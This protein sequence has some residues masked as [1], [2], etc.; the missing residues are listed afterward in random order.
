MPERT[1]LERLAE[2][3]ARRAQPSQAGPNAATPTVAVRHGAPSRAFGPA[4]V[5][6]MQRHA[7]N[8]AVVARLRRSGEDAESTVAGS[9]AQGG[10]MGEMAGDAMAG[11]KMAGTGAAAMVEA[12][13]GGEDGGGAGSAVGDEVA[14]GR[15][16]LSGSGAR[17]E[18]AS[19]AAAAAMAGSS[20][21]ASA[22]AGEQAFSTSGASAGGAAQAASMAEASA[23]SAV[24]GAAS[25][26]MTE[27]GGAAQDGSLAGGAAMGGETAAGSAVSGAASGAMTEHVGAQGAASVAQGAGTEHGGAAQGGETIAGSA[28]S[29]AAQ[30]GEKAVGS[31][32]SGGGAGA[33]TD[34]VGAQGAES[35]AAAAVGGEAPSATGAETA[36]HP[37]AGSRSGGAGAHAEGRT[38]GGAG[39]GGAGAA[40]AGP[41]EDAA[42]GG[43]MG[44]GG[45]PAS[46]EEVDELPEPGPISMA[47]VA[48]LGQP[49]EL[50]TEAPIEEPGEITA[51]EAPALEGQVSGIEGAVGSGGG[52]VLD[53]IVDR[54][55]GFFRPVT[56][57][58]STGLRN[59]ASGVVTRIGNIATSAWTAARGL[60]TSV[61]NGFRSLAG[62]ILGEIRSHLGDLQAG[63]R[64]IVGQVFGAVRG[65]MGRIGGAIRSAVSGILSGRPVMATL[66]A[67][68]KAVF[69]GMFGAIT[70]RIRAI[71][72]R[73]RGVVNG[74]L[75]R[76]VSGAA[77]L[78]Q[79]AQAG[80][81]A[82]GASIASGLDWLQQESE[83]LLGW[84]N[85]LVGELPGLLR[86]AISG[87]VD[88]VLGF[89][90]R[91]LA[92]VFNAA[93]GFINT[94]VSAVNGLVG[95][96][97]NLVTHA[98]NGLRSL[99]TN[100]VTAV[101]NGVQAIGGV[102]SRAGQWLYQ[103][104]AA[105]LSRAVKA[106][107]GPIAER[108]QKRV[109]AM[110]GP[111][112][113]QAIEQAKLMF[114]NGL[115]APEEIA[116]TVTKAAREEASADASAIVAGLTNPE[117]DHLAYG[118]T[119]G[120]SVGGGVG[121]GG[122]IGAT[123]DVVL[124]YRRND[125][126]FFISPQVGGQVNVGD[127]SGTGNLSAVAGW[128]TVGNFGD[129][130]QDVLG[131]YGGFFT[132]ATYGA[133]AGLAVE[134]GVGVSTGGSFY[135]GGATTGIPIVSF[136]PLGADSH[137]IPGTGT[138]GTTTPGTP[139]RPGTL[140]LG[141]VRFP[142]QVAEAPA[143]PGGQAAIDHAADLAL[144]YPG[145]HPGGQ[146]TG[147]DVL[148]GASRVFAQ[149][150]AGRTRE[151]ANR[152]L[153][154]R[155]AQG[156]AELLRVKLPGITVL[157]RGNGDAVAAA[158]G[159]PETDASPE[160]Q[161]AS[162]VAATKEQGTPGTSTPGIPPTQ[163]P[164]QHTFST[165]QLPNPFQAKQ[166]W[167]W[168]TTVGVTGYAGAGA[169]AGVY[170]GAGISYSIPL[171]KTHFDADTMRAIRLNVGFLKLVADIASMSPLGFIRDA[172]GLAAM[173]SEARSV[174][175]E[176]IN[177]ITSWAIDLPP[178]AAVA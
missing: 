3:H 36:G 71:V 82:L 122:A 76:L 162:M 90:R 41:A 46:T 108:M 129:Q 176:I 92:S 161:R 111:A 128:G 112:V 127:V 64:G 27:H 146:V 52:G 97:S 134:G 95:Q 165:L 78:A 119:L 48:A 80:I 154:E 174:E 69:D 115:P 118:V 89:I 5:L 110:I 158:A 109:L 160:D 35:A 131:A 105:G 172:L 114:P 8:R 47:P 135:H 13:A 1:E 10:T 21:G 61:V 49:P 106:V 148:G 104:A 16:R 140:A 123:L 173:S 40:Q 77:A 53:E 62:G 9:E 168:D 136:T 124:D 101:E 37:A 25:G 26:A 58:I 166:A 87:I 12:A 113:G 151:E 86:D 63:V 81:S 120:G 44:G 137:P 29:G 91:I 88:R 150:G 17:G 93:R 14:S 155:R 50:S 149:P 156:T 4:A 125:I 145:G 6:A 67:P 164:N 22:R 103:K 98:V 59:A 138:P 38:G 132:N 42:G 139:D 107:F 169:K 34:H 94:A 55:L 167:G 170:G 60:M 85:E 39:A 99:V 72:D 116:S 74:A 23:G 54:A 45:G 31:A 96:A 7:G 133:Q 163:A 126:G 178:G 19:G 57:R 177:A 159:K 33:M 66:L 24:S 152:A 171:G 68:F 65:V 142:R 30:G 143:A 20:Q 130:G 2:S 43:G 157:A 141:E 153:A 121:V 11:D 51:P 56:S 175:T 28:G 73:I 75:D 84:I 102:M 117:G 83:R 15:T 79:R 144:A 32:A 147:I 100:A 18:Q 70:G